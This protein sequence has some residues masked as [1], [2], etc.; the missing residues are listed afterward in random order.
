MILGNPDVQ[1]RASVN[2]SLLE[3]WQSE[4]LIIWKGKK[5]NVLPYLQKS[6]IA[7]LP[8]YREGFPKSLIEACA[9]GCAIVTTNV[10]GCREVVKKNKNAFLVKPKDHK[11]LAENLEKLILNKKLRRY[12]SKNSRNL[13]NKKYDIKKFVKVNMKEY[14]R[15]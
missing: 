15:I 14:E 3:Q 7:V 1:N 5:K 11:I 10:T 9:S 13:A 8:S 2:V 4:K 6:K 12:F